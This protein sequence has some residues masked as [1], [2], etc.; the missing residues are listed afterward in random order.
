MAHRYTTSFQCPDTGLMVSA[1]YSFG[2]VT[3][4]PC[5]DDTLHTLIANGDISPKDAADLRDKT[6]T[7]CTLHTNYRCASIDEADQ[8]IVQ[9]SNG[10][11]F[12]F[13]RY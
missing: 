3:I 13:D 5:E 8:Y 11:S 7:Y 9:V 12:G 2:K 4:V 1:K 6:E 10:Q